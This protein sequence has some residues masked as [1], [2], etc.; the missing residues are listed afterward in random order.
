MIARLADALLEATVVGSFSSLGYGARQRLF[1]WD[2]EQIDLN[3]RTVV[4]TGG[5][6]GLGRAAATSAARRGATVMITGRDGDK[7]RAAVA[8]IAAASGSD[9]VSFFVADM[10]SLDQTRRLASEV[11]DRV[12]HLDVLVHN[13]GALL[14][15]HRVTEDGM[16]TTFQVHV[17]AP[18]LLT[19]ELLPLL[20]ASPDGRVIWVSSGGMYSQ[21]PDAGRTEMGVDDYDGTAAY[22]RAKRAQVAMASRWAERLAPF[23][24]TAH[25]MHPGWADTPGVEDSLPGFH[26]VVGPI[27]RT[28]AQGADTIVW[29]AGTDPA[30]IGTGRFWH[31]RRPRSAHKVPWTRADDP[32]T[33]VDRLWRLVAERAGL[34]DLVAVPA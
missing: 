20:T 31:D 11:A 29:L 25:V 9:E 12:D 22:A 33:E 30:A 5:T 4:I 14:G 6:S 8:E 15:T 23:G 19:H 34:D 28:P 27:L 18:A 24:V 13:A 7:G 21:R 16:E 17:V 2:D 26:R 32:D 1:A 3:G 10:A